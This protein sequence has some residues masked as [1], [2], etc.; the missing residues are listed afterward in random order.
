MNKGIA[1]ISLILIVLLIGVGG[2]FSVRFFL[3]G[4][5][6]DWICNNGRWVKHGNP[7][8]QKPDNPCPTGVLTTKPTLTTQPTSSVPLPT[9]ED[10]I[11]SFFN[12]INEK[13]IT[14]AISMISQNMV[15]GDST[16]QT[17][18]VHFNAIKSINVMNI[19]PSM[20]ESWSQDKHSYKVTLEVYVSSE[21][22]NAPTPYYGWGDNPNIL[23]ITL[24]KEGDFWKIAELA[25]GP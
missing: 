11:R 8:A 3:G 20:K 12:H 23:W 18:G 19:E 9:E 16:K 5:E 2:L 15:G 14:E 13:R 17:W 21:A 22:A 24:I 10:I 4:N 6:D 1:L 25:T 7:S